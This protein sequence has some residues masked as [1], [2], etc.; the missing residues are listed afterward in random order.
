MDLKSFA[1]TS[2]YDAVKR[3][4]TDAQLARVHEEEEQEKS[5]VWPEQH[6]VKLKNYLDEIYFLR[7][8]YRK[9]I[10]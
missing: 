4:L 7:W 1:W 6:T 5:F 9:G 2:A 8:L 10:G 3:S